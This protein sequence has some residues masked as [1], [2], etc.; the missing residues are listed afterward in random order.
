M[1]FAV[2]IDKTLPGELNET[3]ITSKLTNAI[4]FSNRP[5]R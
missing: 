4:N 2:S 1:T 3:E 5:L